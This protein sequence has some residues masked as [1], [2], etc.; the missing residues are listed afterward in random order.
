ML[1]KFLGLAGQAIGVGNGIK[2]L[3]GGGS[4]AGMSMREWRRHQDQLNQANPMEIQRQLQFME[5]IV[6]GEIQ[7]DNR[8]REGT[9]DSRVNEYEAFGQAT[10]RN[11]QHRNQLLYPDL[12]QWELAGVPHPSSPTPQVI[13]KN[14]KGVNQGAMAQLA[15]AATQQDTAIKTASI[16][17]LTQL[18]TASM[19][20]ETSKDVANINTR[21]LEGQLE[22]AQQNANTQEEAQKALATL[23]AIKGIHTEH[24]MAYKDRKLVVE[25]LE[26]I[27]RVLPQNEWDLMIGQVREVEGGDKLA[28]MMVKAMNGT[29]SFAF[30]E[31]NN[32][33]YTQMKEILSSDMLFFARSAGQV[34]RQ[35]AD[36]ASSV[37]NSLSKMLGINSRG[38]TKPRTSRSTTRRN[39]DGSSTRTTI[40][41]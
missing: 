4:E 36:M 15:S 14:D 20:N 10:N 19:N 17:S 18:A 31:F 7:Y 27:S 11:A 9:L 28:D 33:D 25:G 3:F 23:Q 24:D 2:S 34:G 21:T 26:R 41:E 39:P 16:Q 12:N 5:G 13:P 35:G 22:V 1:G 30:S 40:Y 32:H 37:F 8:M 29:T 6:D 38:P